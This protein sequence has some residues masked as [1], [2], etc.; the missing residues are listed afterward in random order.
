MG[1]RLNPNL[2]KIHRNYTV[3]E[4]AG[5]FSVH[6]NTVRSWVK[7]GLPTS[8]NLRPMLILGSAL[9]L[10]LQSKRKRNKRKCQPFE[11]YCVRCRIP[12]IPA[13]NM[14]DFEPTN[15][16]KGCLIGLCP[17]CDVIINKFFKTAHLVQLR[18]KL[19]VTFTKAL[20]HI[21][22]SSNPPV[23]SDFKE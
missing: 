5:L 2:V 6:K 10:Y 17:S 9:K 19:E 7:D 16:N 22:E 14:V 21:V 3:G 13:G 12:Q 15:S 8:D 20:E 1:K 11:I 23:N 18:D 4:V